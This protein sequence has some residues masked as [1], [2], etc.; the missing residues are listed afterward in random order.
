MYELTEIINKFKR[1]DELSDDSLLDNYFVNKKQ[2]IDIFY[3]IKVL[4][5]TFEDNEIEQAYK[6][7]LGNKYEEYYNSDLNKIDMLKIVDKIILDADLR[8]WEVFRDYELIGGRTLQS[9]ANEYNIT[10]ERI[11]QIK[12]KVRE[13]VI[14]SYKVKIVI[15][16]VYKNIQSQS[17]SNLFISK[18]L[19]FDNKFVNFGESNNE[20]I[21]NVSLMAYVLGLN[22][23]ETDKYYVFTDDKYKTIDQCLESKMFSQ[24][25]ED[26]VY[27]LTIFA[28]KKMI[29]EVPIDYLRDWIVDK[30]WLVVYDNSLYF[31]KRK[32]TKVDKCKFVL[33]LLGEP[34]H[35]S[36]VHSLYTKVYGDMTSEHSVHALMDRGRDEGIVRTF[37]GTFGLEELGEKQHISIQD[38]AVGIMK[39][40]V[41]EYDLNDLVIDIMKYTEAKHNS[42]VTTLFTNKTFLITKESTIILRK[43]N[44]QLKLEETTG[45]NTFNEQ[46]IVDECDYL[47]YTINEFTIKYNRIRIPLGF[48]N[49]IKPFVNC[50]F[51]NTELLLKYDDNSRL[52]VGINKLIDELG[53]CQGDS[54]FMVFHNDTFYIHKELGE[55]NKSILDFKKVD[56]N[57]EHVDSILQN[58]FGR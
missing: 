29:D 48:T 45:K 28:N 14:R 20:V 16:D 7:F 50:A 15:D 8:S 31:R 53:L 27:N 54:F 2:I 18:D 26:K 3:D 9:I 51:K 37:T 40:E 38:I 56:K 33:H 34:S 44:N 1:I 35:Y 46:G 21:V 17:E 19:F 22:F 52:L 13:R 5:R 58:L 39:D 41:R 43:W 30:N 32:L 11:R 42:I 55:F 47:K 24:L 12:K 57:V 23:F 10:R 4:G 6:R 25:E 36:D 49:T